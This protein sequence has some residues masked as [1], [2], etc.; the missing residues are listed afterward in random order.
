MVI[1]PV[2]GN[3]G[4]VPT[5]TI[6]ITSNGLHNVAVYANALINVP[7][8]GSTLITKTITTN[9]IYAAV[10]DHADGYSTVTVNVPGSVPV[11]TLSVTENGTY[12]CSSYASV[13]V[14][15]QG[16][17][18]SGTISIVANGSYDVA[19]YANAVI[20]VPNQ[21]E[22]A[23][24]NSNGVYTPSAGKIGFG[25]VTV[26]V[27]GAD[28]KYLGLPVGA[29]CWKIDQTTGRL[30]VEHDGT[31]DFAGVRELHE[32]Y[33][34]G[35]FEN[36]TLLTGTARFD[37]L[38][39]ISN[40]YGI[41]KTFNNCSGLTGASFAKLQEVNSTNGSGA[42]DDDPTRGYYYG[43]RTFYGTNLTFFSAPLLTTI[44]GVGAFNG[45][46]L[47]ISTLTNVNLAS[48][49]TV[50]GDHACNYM[51]YGCGIT[52]LD[53]TSLTTISGSRGCAYMFYDNSIT[54]TLDLSNLTTISGY[55]GAYEMF[56]NNSIT[57]LRLDSLAEI[58][59]SNAAYGMF[60]YNSD[61]IGTVSLPSLV[62][63]S[64]SYAM[65]NFISYCSNITGFSAPS[66]PAVN[67]D[68]VCAFL[69]RGCSKLLSADLSSLTTITGNQ[70]F[71]YAFDGCE[72]LAAFPFVAVTTING[73]YVF[74]NCF[75]GCS[76]I[77]NY[78]FN[79]VTS[80]TGSNVFCDMFGDGRYNTNDFVTSITFDGL[81][82]INGDYCMTG[83]LYGNLENV[84]SLRFKS[85][86]TVTGE[87]ALAHL[88]GSDN[89]SDT[90][91]NKSYIK[92]LYFDS[93]SHVEDYATFY[94]LLSRPASHYDYDTSTTVY[95][96]LEDI[97]FYA[98]TPS[99]FG[100]LYTN[101]FD[102]MLYGQTDTT[103]HFPK[104]IQSTIGSW[105][106]V[107]GGFGGTNITTVFDIVTSLTGADLN[108]YTRFQKLSTDTYTCWKHND[109]VYYT[110][111]TSE[112]TVGTTIY[113]DSACSI[114]VTTVSTIA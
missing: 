91:Y 77:S 18:A 41:Q 112:P 61:L 81:T 48:L 30:Y 90:N 35:Y 111:G 58:S 31:P 97:Y 100:S 5:G 63:V 109:V 36:W 52:T 59:N 19:Q 32:S 43:Q 67:G 1:Q 93:L 57:G 104:A 27:N 99:S 110:S 105:S 113:S 108:V 21:V 92:K 14:D 6:E 83:L 74:E 50:S 82:T 29:W 66:L 101:Q 87:Y 76:R 103:V 26:Q 102:N 64:G 79:S 68:Y 69:C 40:C 12:D 88:I 33:L 16:G 106:S 60:E 80:V 73:N 9:G 107:T 20:N 42:T 54:G 8:G 11:G 15:V 86:T 23:I 4:I 56:Y 17:S 72:R 13:N 3:G 71:H 49:Q 46:C 24:F 51:F 70:A 96:Y 10:N 22:N 7:T 84:T 53:I 37:D 2:A 39:L 45:C 34:T 38:E 95:D 85:L 114:A 28:G 75:S 25:Q 44:S 78:N 55:Y 65:N 47:S 94:Y 98:L 62:T 89:M